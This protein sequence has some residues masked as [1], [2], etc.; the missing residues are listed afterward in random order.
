MKRRQFL[1]SSGTLL[2]LAAA[3]RSWGQVRPCAPPVIAVS[4][5]GA[6]ATNC[7]GSRPGKAPAWFEAMP[8]RS[9]QQ[10]PGC[11]T[12]S[13]VKPV[14]PPRGAEGQS[15]VVDD[16]T[17]GCV[18]QS[19]G[20][21]Y[22]PWQGGH[23][24]YYG[25]EVYAIALRSESPQWVR[26]TDP[27]P[28]EL[29]G[30]LTDSYANVQSDGSSPMTAPAYPSGPGPYYL[31]YLDGRPRAVHGW[32]G[33]DAADG[34]I[35]SWRGTAAPLSS[36][37]DTNIWTFNRASLARV[38]LP[39]SG[40]YE[41]GGRG[42][43]QWHGMMFPP[44]GY[45]SSFSSQAGPVCYDPYNKKVWFCAEWASSHGVCSLDLGTLGA[46]SID[47]KTFRSSALTVYDIYVP[48]PGL[49][50][51][52]PVV[53]PHS[54]DVDGE[55]LAVVDRVRTY[56]VV[57][58]VTDPEA[59]LLWILNL[60][61]PAQ[62]FRRVSTTGAPHGHFDGTGAAYH[63][64]SRA[65]LTWSCGKASTNSQQSYAGSYASFG[66]GLRRLAM[67]A[68][69]MTAPG[70]EFRWSTIDANAASIVPAPGAN[71]DQ[72][73]G[74]YGKLR[75]IN[76]MGSGAGALVTVLDVNGPTYVYKLPVRV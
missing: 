8:E 23:N 75:M 25:N 16:W 66:S 35:I 13:S 32:F 71:H 17:G 3:G 73:R 26:L 22:L 36:G 67:P 63:A 15:A 34:R 45:P 19:V 1:T 74:V 29:Y 5:G 65:V 40:S 27:T 61:D 57:G 20:E 64:A 10:I 70:S 52:W 47:P 6:T 30:K 12:L 51:G 41:V 68:D 46:E 58:A 28:V 44:S 76:D 18:D 54:A 69:P 24:G 38:P 9:W 49:S 11:N 59:Q 43:F 31:S 33:M 42:P 2:A 56:L 72:F 14:V 55:G 53:V 50:S 39:H 7:S 48:S 21:F 62:G 60:Q 4:G 37:K